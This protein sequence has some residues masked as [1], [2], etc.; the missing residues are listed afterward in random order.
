MPFSATLQVLACAYA[1]MQHIP[2]L[3]GLHRWMATGHPLRASPSAE[4]EPWDES[5]A[6]PL[7]PRTGTGICTS[8]LPAPILTLHYP[9]IPLN[10]ILVSFSSSIL[11]PLI[12]LYPPTR[13]T[14][15]PLFSLLLR[16]LLVACFL[17]P[18]LSISVLLQ[19]TTE[20]SSLQYLVSEFTLR[21]Q[22]FE[23]Q[24]RACGILDGQDA[25]W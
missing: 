21:A 7:F 16:V 12:H 17:R 20:L 10:I 4:C 22:L 25:P 24:F 8:H 9:Y 13:Y 11:R 2:P 5:S 14:F 23:P 19:I 15:C 18:T 1:D 6:N 3:T